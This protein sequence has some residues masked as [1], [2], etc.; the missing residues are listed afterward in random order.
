M[1]HSYFERQIERALFMHKAMFLA[2]V[3]TDH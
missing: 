1:N 3:S 2:R